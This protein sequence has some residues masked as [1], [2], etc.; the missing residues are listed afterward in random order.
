VGAVSWR[1][2]SSQTER[3]GTRELARTNDAIIANPTA[4]DSGMKSDRET[5][6]MKNDGTKTATTESMA[7]SRGTTTSPLASSTARATGVPRDKC[8]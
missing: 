5:P 6:V 8:V 2:P 1:R 3:T 7:S 4:R